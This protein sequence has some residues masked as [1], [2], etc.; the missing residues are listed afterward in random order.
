MLNSGEGRPVLGPSGRRRRVRR[1]YVHGRGERVQ[2][3]VRLHRERVWRMMTREGY[4]R[5]EDAERAIKERELSQVAYFQDNYGVH[6][7]DES[8]YDMKL[9]TSTRGIGLVALKIVHAVRG[10]RLAEIA[11]VP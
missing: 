9:Q 6:P 8:L 1:W 5:P 4:L 11:A 7:H 2:L 3:P 10:E